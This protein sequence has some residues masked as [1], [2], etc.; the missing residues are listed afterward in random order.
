MMPIYM[1][2]IMLFITLWIFFGNLLVLLAFFF[3][4]QIRSVDNMIIGSL[5]FNDFLLS[6]SVAPLAIFNLVIILNMFIKLVLIGS[7]PQKYIRL[8]T[9]CLE[10]LFNSSLFIIRT[11]SCRNRFMSA[12]AFL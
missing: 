6:L 9:K 11:L 3:I 8:E 1:L 10:S 2:V 4:K 5:S 12:Y 7:V